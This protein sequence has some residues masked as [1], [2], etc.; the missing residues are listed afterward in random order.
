MFDFTVAQIGVA[1]VSRLMH[2]EERLGVWCDALALA[3]SDLRERGVEFRDQQVSGGA[4]VDVILDPNRQRRVEECRGKVR[5]HE[6]CLEGYRVTLLGLAQQNP[7]ATYPCTVDD[8]V[9]LGLVEEEKS[10]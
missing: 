6:H 4:R 7:D 2:H 5:E 8:I 1:C 9:W 3:E 10:S